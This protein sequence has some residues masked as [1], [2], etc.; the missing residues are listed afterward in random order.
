MPHRDDIVAVDLMD[1]VTNQLYAGKAGP[2]KRNNEIIFIKM[3][4]HAGM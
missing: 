3:R 1:R 4:A 2:G